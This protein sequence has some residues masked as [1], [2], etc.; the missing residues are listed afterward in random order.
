MK[1]SLYYIL[2]LTCS[3]SL[4]TL[5]F[6]PSVTHLKRGQVLDFDGL[7]LAAKCLVRLC[8]QGNLAVAAELIKEHWGHGMREDS[9]R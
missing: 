3:Y 7:T 6:H 5:G 8:E 2:S 1:C 9:G 4:A